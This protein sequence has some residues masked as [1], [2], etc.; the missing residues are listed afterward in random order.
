MTISTLA[1]LPEWIENLGNDLNTLWPIFA[2]VAG[3]YG[4]YRATRRAFREEVTEIV[5]QEITPMKAELMPNGGSSIKD[6]VDKLY[7]SHVDALR[8]SDAV[9]ADIYKALG[10]KMDK[11]ECPHFEENNP[12]SEGEGA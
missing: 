11:S 9:H 6:K 12:P 10:H 3:I 5:K 4:F 7:E 2:A 1:A 8:T